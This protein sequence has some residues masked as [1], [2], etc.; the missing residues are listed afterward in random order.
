MFAA[1]AGVEAS[2]PRH[3]AKIGV[4]PRDRIYH[5]G[6]VD[7]PPPVDPQ[8]RAKADRQVPADRGLRLSKNIKNLYSLNIK[9]LRG[10]DWRQWNDCPLPFRREIYC[11]QIPM[12]V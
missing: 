12:D 5:T 2:A 8:K 1:M 11:L 10:A 3:C 7:D 6:R 4:P 9:A